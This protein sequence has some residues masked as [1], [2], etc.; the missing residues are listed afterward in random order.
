MQLAWFSP[1]LLAAASIAV[2]CIGSAAG[3][4]E[5]QLEVCSTSIA[6]EQ[7]TISYDING[8][9]SGPNPWL[10]DHYTFREIFFGD[11]GAVTCPS[12]I[13]LATIAPELTPKEKA[14]HCL[15]WNKEDETYSGFSKGERN[16]FGAC[17]NPKTVCERVSSAK[18]K[19]LAAISAAGTV[20]SVPSVAGA[21]G[22]S[23]VTHSSGAAILTGS[24]GYIAGT[25]GSV[26]ASALATIGAVVTAPAT[27]IAGGL[28]VAAIGGATYI[29]WD[30]LTRSG[31]MAD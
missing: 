20:A 27:I 4:E 18:G 30:E 14:A 7:R 25:L 12:A 28:S 24:S 23:A 3:A 6:G 13:T 16:A 19:A 10:Y 29:C 22:V 1:A 17:K 11:W 26:G 21:A 8:H 5:V 2:A 31:E 15:V 9:W